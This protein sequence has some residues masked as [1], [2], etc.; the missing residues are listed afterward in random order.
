MFPRLHSLLSSLTALCAF[1]ACADA[2]SP[3]NLRV[4]HQHG[5]SFVTFD[6]IAGYD[7]EYRVYRSASPIAAT[8]ELRPIATLRPGS[9]LNRLHRPQTMFTITHDGEPLPTDT[10]LLVWTTAEPGEFHYAVTTPVDEAIVGG[11]NATARPVLETVVAPQAYRFDLNGKTAHPIDGHYFM[12]DDYAKWDPQAGYYGTA[13]LVSDR[14]ARAATEA[15]EKRPLAVWLHG[16]GVT[17]PGYAGWT[18]GGPAVWIVTQDWKWD[19]KEPNPYSGRKQPHSFWFGYGSDG[20]AYNWTQE[21]I[22]R[23]IEYLKQHPPVNAD[24]NRVYVTGGSMGGGGSLKLAWAYPDTFAATAVELPWI[25]AA[26]FPAAHKDMI[27]SFGGVDAATSWPARSP[28]SDPWWERA[29]ATW[30]QAVDANWLAAHAPPTVQ[31]P[32][33]ALFYRKDDPIILGQGVPAFLAALEDRHQHFTAGWRDGKHKG[34]GQID[35]DQAFFNDWNW[36]RSMFRFRKDEAYLAFSGAGDD[37]DVP[38]AGSRNL[39]VDWSSSLRDLWPDSL[40]DAMVDRADEFSVTL[41]ALT[42]D[43]VKVAITPRNTIAFRPRPGQTVDWRATARDDGRLLASGS[44][45]ADDRGLVNLLDVP[46]LSV[47]TRLKLTQSAN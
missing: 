18:P 2:A 32:P 38:A 37:L 26:A 46:V 41:K 28:Y 21:R 11:V 7:G 22:V 34:Y 9:G 23:F 1:V 45:A 47:G 5:Q 30:A 19:E 35:G 39:N 12:W 40:K 43:A 20:V 27:G 29:G 24:A 13:F 15:G 10:G 6:E 8:T 25:D 42:G 17:G 36:G 14:T 16:A 33:V 4:L 44:V 3:R 31:L